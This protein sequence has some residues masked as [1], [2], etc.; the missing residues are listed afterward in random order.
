MF[1]KNTKSSH[2]TL[3]I[4]H[5]GARSLSPENTIASAKKAFEVGADGWEIDVQITRDKK[6]VVVHEESLTRTSNVNE[7][8]MKDLIK[9]GVDGIITDFPQKLSKVLNVDFC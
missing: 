2:Q 1:L 8:G 5:R 7:R 6:L 3:N 9:V 4:A